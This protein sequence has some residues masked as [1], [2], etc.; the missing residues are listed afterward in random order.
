MKR[1]PL[2]RPATTG[3]RAAALVAVAVG[4][5]AAGIGLGTRARAVAGSVKA[6]AVAATVR[7]GAAAAIP[8]FPRE[9]PV[10]L[11]SYPAD[12]DCLVHGPY[13]HVSI[14]PRV[15]HFGQTIAIT[16]SAGLPP[17]TTTR[18]D[19]CYSSIGVIHE[20]VLPT[21]RF[22]EATSPDFSDP[23][24][25]QRLLDEITSPCKAAGMSVTERFKVKP[26]TADGTGTPGG[27][28]AVAAVMN[29][30]GEGLNTA[31]GAFYASPKHG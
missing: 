29:V 3:L 1:T 13:V 16:M 18:T 7:A 2:A 15:V 20:R 19:R 11:S 24:G 8:R 5:L 28:V 21:S 26:S 14:S 4:S 12:A 23:R 17:C 22:A 31:E 6:S 10:N 27:W 30:S 9:C 25:C